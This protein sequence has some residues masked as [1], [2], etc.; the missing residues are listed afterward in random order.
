MLKM[1]PAEGWKKDE[2]NNRKYEQEK[3]P[4]DHWMVGSKLMLC[5]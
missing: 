2:D 4:E 1:H 3:E 5:M